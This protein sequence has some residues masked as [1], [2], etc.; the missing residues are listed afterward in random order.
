MP[1]ENPKRK[2]GQSSKGG[3][4]KAPRPLKAMAFWVILILVL[5]VAFQMFE[6]G[7]TPEYRISYS[8]FHK[9]I[10]DGNIHSIVIKGLEVRGTLLTPTIIPIDQSRRGQGK[11]REVRV[12]GFTVVLPVADESLPDEI[13]AANENTVIEGEVPG[14]SLWVKLLTS[15]LPL[16][17]I[18][19]RENANRSPWPQRR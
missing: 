2:S 12:E 11:Q 17:L 8:E 1:D 9:Q 19:V 6:M 5:L 15:G 4:G 3:L 14:G 16:L 13:L 10:A 7:K 18:V